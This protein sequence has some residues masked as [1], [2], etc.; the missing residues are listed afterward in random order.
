MKVKIDIP[1]VLLDG[2]GVKYV[3]TGEFR[4]VKIGENFLAGINMSALCTAIRNCNTD[5]YFIYKRK[6]KCITT[7]EEV[8]EWARKHPNQIVRQRGESVSYAGDMVFSGKPSD[9]EFLTNYKRYTWDKLTE[10]EV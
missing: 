4:N 7:Q 8:I 2:N 9:Y 3:P 10:I 6:V 1:D 5:K